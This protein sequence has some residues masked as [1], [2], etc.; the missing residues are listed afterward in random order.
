MIELGNFG[1]KLRHDVRLW[2]LMLV[3]LVVA[4]CAPDQMFVAQ[5]ND[6]VI[7][8]DP[9][10]VTASY[11]S[12]Q[13]ALQDGD[14]LEASRRLNRALEADPANVV[15]RRQ[16]FFLD[17]SAGRFE[18]ALEHAAEL[19]AL[20]P[21]MQEPHLL[22]GLDAA[23]QGDYATALEKF[24]AIDE[25]GVIGLTVPLMR[26]WSLFGIGEQAAAID[27]F[28]DQVE[29]SGLELL[30]TYHRGLAL[31]LMGNHQESAAILDETITGNLDPVRVVVATAEA[32][33]AAGDLARASEILASELELSPENVVLRQAFDDLTGDQPLALPTQTPPTAMADALLG[34]A[35]AV[36]RQRSD[37]RGILLGQMAAM[38]DPQAGDIQLFLARTFLAQDRPDTAIATLENLPSGTP[39][40]WESR[41]LRAEALH[42]DDRTRDAIRLLN[43]MAAERPNRTDALVALGDIHRRSENYR[44]AEQSYSRAL[45]RVSDPASGHWRLYYSRGI[46]YERTQRWPAAEADFEQALALFPD[47]P[48]VLNYLG[49]SWVD[50]NLNLERAEQMLVKAVELRPNDGFIVDSLGWAYYRLGRFD[51]A[52]EYLERA[53]ELQP[54]DPVI[55]DHLGDAYWRAGRKREARFQWE[56]ALTFGAEPDIV[57]E[58]ERKLQRGLPAPTNG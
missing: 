28:A 30:T 48:L 56:R 40:T 25:R 12:G 3:T 43:D 8:A 16:V 9:N 37:A 49:Y 32:H 13:V 15:L 27:D 5:R 20:E 44:D 10:N 47:Q 7:S 21:S 23:N 14:I 50:Q 39:W 35:R 1:R 24:A 2:P 33:R 58:I 17:V 38:L 53:V 42:R 55:N 26:A 29:N 54:G 4:G 36:E 11:L 45:D 52:V 6:A 18:R 46:T 31:M 51:E 57:A 19:A 34:L 41:L 22:L